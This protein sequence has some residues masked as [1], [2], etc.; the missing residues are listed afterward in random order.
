[1]NLAFWQLIFSFGAELI[2]QFLSKADY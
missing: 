2:W 1:M